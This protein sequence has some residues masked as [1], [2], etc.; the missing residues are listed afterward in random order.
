MRAKKARA[1]ES[2]TPAMPNEISTKPP[3]ARKYK[4]KASKHESK[5]NFN[6]WRY[7]FLTHRMSDGTVDACSN[8][9]IGICWFWEWCDILW[10]E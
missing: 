2:V 9:L 10:S 3:S 5:E 1:A 6:H 4:E 7:S 8:K